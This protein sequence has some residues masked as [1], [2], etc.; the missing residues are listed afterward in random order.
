MRLESEGA[1]KFFGEPD[2]EIT[3]FIQTEQGKGVINILAADK[4]MSSPRVYT[5]FLLWL[6]D[7]LYETLPEVGDL[8]KP[9]LIFFFDEAHLLFNDMPSSLLEK[10]EQIVRL[11]RSKGVG[12]YFCTQNP[13]D[14]P[15]AILGSWV[16]GYSTPYELTRPTTRRRSAWR[17]TRSVPT[18]RSIPWRRLPNSTPVRHLSRS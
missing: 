3:D 6:L 4:L 12:V 2:L 11:I 7:D 5:T 13:A 15:P 17:P 8:D 1:D 10:V 14:I 9:K 18:P 16:T